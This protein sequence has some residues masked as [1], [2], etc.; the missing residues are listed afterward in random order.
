[1]VRSSPGLWGPYNPHLIFCFIPL[2]VAIGIAS[3]LD[4][5]ITFKTYAPLWRFEYLMNSFLVTQQ[6]SEV[7][8]HVTSR[9][10][11]GGW[12]VSH[13]ASRKQQHMPPKNV[14]ELQFLL[15]KHF[16]VTNPHNVVMQQAVDTTYMLTPY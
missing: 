2:V 1:M 11:E 14:L 12:A 16:L 15:S 3:T 13:L 8:E 6:L 7:S 4:T 5:P 9:I 10:A